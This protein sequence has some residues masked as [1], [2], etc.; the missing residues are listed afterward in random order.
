MCYF[1]YFA[2]SVTLPNGTFFVTGGQ[3]RVGSGGY[4]GS[5][6]RSQPQATTE[7]LIRGEDFVYGIDMPVA[8]SEHCAVAVAGANASGGLVVVLGG[9]GRSHVLDLA[10]GTWRSAGSG[11]TEVRSGHVCG[12]A[13]NKD[14]VVVAGGMDGGDIMIVASE[15]LDLKTMEWREGEF[16]NR[17][18]DH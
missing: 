7:L 11:S 8:L 9:R 6:G 15:I 18:I 10:S 17:A 5:G 14:E 12:L 13:G 1:R 4:F 2:A 3:V 16:R